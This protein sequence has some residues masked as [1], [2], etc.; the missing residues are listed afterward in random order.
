MKGQGR[1]DRRL[2]L[3]REL[4]TGRRPMRSTGSALT[5]FGASS[6]TPRAWGRLA[7]MT[8]EDKPYAVFVGATVA[9]FAAVALPGGLEASSDWRGYALAAA[10]VIA[11]GMGSSIGWW[12]CF[13]VAF[14]ASVGSTLVFIDS[15]FQAAHSLETMMAITALVALTRTPLCRFYVGPYYSV[16][17]AIA[18]HRALSTGEL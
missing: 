10:A 5:A 8:G 17:G 1:S 13:L 11:V 3:P 7:R 4:T 2:A 18:R 14:R 9:C 6:G 16:Q 12:V 15:G